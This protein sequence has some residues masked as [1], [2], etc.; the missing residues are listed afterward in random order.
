MTLVLVAIVVLTVS[1]VCCSRRQNTGKAKV[2]TINPI[3][4]EYG[5]DVTN[6]SLHPISTTMNLGENNRSIYDESCDE[7]RMQFQSQRGKL[8]TQN[9]NRL[10]HGQPTSRLHGGPEDF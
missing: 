6:I 8:T 4:G 1:C 10:T 5:T 7:N 9:A 3:D 2:K